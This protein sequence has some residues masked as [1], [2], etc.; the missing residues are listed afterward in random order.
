MN[1]PSRFSPPSDARHVAAQILLGREGRGRFIEQRIDTSPLFG[2]LSQQD[3][4]LAHELTFGV[5]RQQSILDWLIS[6]RTGGRAQP[7][8][9]SELLRLGLYQILWLD[10]IPPHAAVNESVRLAKQYGF[11]R[12]SGFVNAVLR[13]VL[14]QE[15]AV[16]SQIKELQQKQP[17]IGYSH[18][19][20]LTDRWGARYGEE[21][22]RRLLEWDN[23]PAVTYARVN[24]LRTDAGSLLEDWRREGV[25]YEFFTRDWTGENLMFELRKHPPLT[26]LDSFRAGKFYIQ[27]PS[28][29]LAIQHLHLQTG[30]R[31]LDFCAAPGGKTTFIAQRLGNQGDIIAHDADPAR[32]DML[33]QNAEKLGAN[34]IRVVPPG[35]PCGAPGSFDAVLLDAPCSNTG[36]LRRRIELRWRLEPAELERIVSEQIE[37]LARASALVKPDGLL[38]YSTCSLE[39]EENGDCVKVFLAKHPRFS[40]ETERQLLPYKDGVDGAYVARLRR[41]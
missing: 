27:D 29:L 6:D 23:T 34:C 16:R 26:S 30:Q 4:G 40:L 2:N 1:T 17:D 13:N 39:P 21:N 9:I 36:V 41:A 15:P 10:R 5:L 35:A 19:R 32:F 18:P 11:D 14:R 25:E 20:W 38:V 7:A 31:V 28:T 12:E 33:R 22:M 37:L 8:E 3:R 24:T